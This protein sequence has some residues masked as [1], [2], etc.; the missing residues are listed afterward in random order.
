MRKEMRTYGPME[1]SLLTNKLCSGHYN[2]SILCC[3]LD[4]G[5]CFTYC[6][7]HLSLHYFVLIYVVL[8][9][10]YEMIL[11]LVC[12]S[13]LNVHVEY[14]KPVFFWDTSKSLSNFSITSHCKF[15][16]PCFALIAT[17][18]N[19]Y[20]EHPQQIGRCWFFPLS[21]RGHLHEHKNTASL[22]V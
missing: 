1:K 5:L 16:S 19:P 7:V 8:R 14:L 22:S 6:F 11:W 13:R 2:N 10:Q 9:L 4:F 20:S 18:L 12:P 17:S 3:D 15:P 21:S